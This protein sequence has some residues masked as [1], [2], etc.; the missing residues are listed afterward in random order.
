VTLS[1]PHSGTST[2]SHLADLLSP[3]V[4][5]AGTDPYSCPGDLEVALNPAAWR[6]PHLARIDEHLV[7][8]EQRTLGTRGLMVFMQPRA[9]KS[10]RCS[11]VFPTWYLRRHPDHRIILGTYG[12]TLGEKHSRWVRNTI[13]ARPELGLRLALDSRRVDD[14]QLA[15]TEGGLRTAGVGGAVTGMG[16]DLLII[17]DPV[18]NREQAESQVYRDKTWDWWTDDLST[19]FM[20]GGV[21]LLMMTR[22]HEDD[23]AG[24]LLAEEPEHWTVLTLPAIAE[25]H[26]ALDRELGET[27]MP[28]R[29]GDEWMAEQQRRLGSYSFGALYQQRPSPAGGSLFK[30][31][32]FRYWEPVVDESDKVLWKVGDQMV[33]P[34]DCWRFATVDTASSTKTSAD[35]T[36]VSC[37]AVTPNSDLVLLDRVRQR[38]EEGALL[39]FIRTAADRS[40][41]RWI[42]LES[43]F[44]TT[45]LGY[46]MGTAGLKVVP[47]KA[48]T[49]KITRSIPAQVRTEQHR[50]Y[51]PSGASWLDEWEH[52]LLAFPNGTHDDQVDTFSYAALRLDVRGPKAKAATDDSPQARIRRQLDERRRARR[53]GPAPHGA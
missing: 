43:T 19:R 21:A 36:V 28:D 4:V 30:R 37:W 16:A 17:D 24:R 45:T 26:D 3:H 25:E 7:S 2:L 27:L 12:K 47:L 5:D 23:L 40:A 42:G 53:G 22:W 34:A 1:P 18:K 33:T 46:E 8:L 15:D 39:D 51:F 31:A 48:D 11:R 6:Y 44:A 32:D 13:T 38:M 20:S 50:V 10:Q 14:W 35:W 52:E 29:Y 41:C 49:D 9:G